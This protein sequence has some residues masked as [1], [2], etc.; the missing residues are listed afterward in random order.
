M[1]MQS[2]IWS[3]IAAGVIVGGLLM[4]GVHSGDG[5]NAT[6]IDQRSAG[7][8]ITRHDGSA[9]VASDAETSVQLYRPLTSDG[10]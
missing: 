9:T 7:G 6:P 8:E 10:Q 2:K 3:L 5:S 4:V 1:R